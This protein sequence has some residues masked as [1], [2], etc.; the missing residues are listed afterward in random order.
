MMKPYGKKNVTRH[1]RE[2]FCAECGSGIDYSKTVQGRATLRTIKRRARAAG[3]RE[4]V[5]EVA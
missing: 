4:I 3:R 1:C 2:H 5:Q